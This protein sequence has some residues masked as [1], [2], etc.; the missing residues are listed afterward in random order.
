MTKVVLDGFIVVPEGDLELVRDELL[1]HTVLT[2]GEPGC[3][4]FKVDQCPEDRCKFY[5]YEEFASEA[6]FQRHQDRSL[7]S[8]WGLVT[9]D[10]RR[11]YNINR[12]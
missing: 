9:K 4:V 3:I 1:L 10:I 11:Y 12:V 5:V 2:R 7:T 6:S 8:R